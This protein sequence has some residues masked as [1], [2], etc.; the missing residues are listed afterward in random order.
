MAILS[1][2]ASAS[3]DD[4]GG[5]VIFG[6]ENRKTPVRRQ[7]NTKSN[8]ISDGA[9]SDA[10]AVVL[11]LTSRHL[12][13]GSGSSEAP[14]IERGGGRLASALSSDSSSSAKSTSSDLVHHVPPLLPPTPTPVLK[15]WGH[16][17]RF[18]ERH[19][20][21]FLA[22]GALVTY[23]GFTAV[24]EGVFRSVSAKNANIGGLVTILTSVVYCVLAGCERGR[25]G[26]SGRRGEWKDYFT[27]ALLTSSSMY[28][29]NAALRYLNYTTRIVAKSSKVIPT[30]ILGTA[31]QGR[32]YTWS[33]YGAAALLVLGI[34]MFTM[35]DVDSLPNFSPTGV[36]LITISLFPDSAAGNFEERRF[37]NVP[38]PSTHAEVVYHSN[39]VG[40]ALT[41]VVMVFT[42][43]LNQA[44]VS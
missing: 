40:F 10:D 37:F 16:E 8:I 41:A 26:E 36:V 35:G 2:S 29:T 1:R 33:E 32:R 15:L 7:P 17:L 18:R 22:L 39:M 42:G 21:I 14:D 34:A 28:A 9:E 4:G 38:N 6:G 43:E 27:L 3:A 13:S 24:Q 11:G 23:L 19:M 20:M 25:N 31:M 5:V 30:M 12:R 44:T